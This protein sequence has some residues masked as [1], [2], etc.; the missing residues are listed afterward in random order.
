MHRGICYSDAAGPKA[1]RAAIG[2]VK[3]VNLYQLHAGHLL[4][5]KLGDALSPSDMD[6]LGGIDIDG[7]YLKFTTIVRVNEAWGIG[8]REAKLEGHAAAGLHKAGV[9][10]GDSDGEA[11]RYELAFEGS[12]GHVLVGTQV[13]ASITK[14]G[15]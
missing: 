7:H 15:I 8:H 2:I 10:L 13:E 9:T 6:R 5:D 12:K 4:Y 14:I 1:A 11:G 3:L